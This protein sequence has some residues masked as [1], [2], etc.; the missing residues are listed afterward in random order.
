[1][2]KSLLVMGEDEVQIPGGAGLCDALG[3]A[4][5]AFLFGRTAS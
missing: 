2:Y 5:G 4:Y 1:M 3:Q